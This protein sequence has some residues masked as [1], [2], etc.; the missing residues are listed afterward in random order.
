[1]VNADKSINLARVAR[2]PTPPAAGA[3]PAPAPAPAPS[4]AGPAITSPKIDVAKVVITGGDYRFT[5]RSIEPHV[6]MAI[7]E[8]TGTVAGLSSANLAKADLDLKAVVNGAGPV[9]ITGKVD[10]LGTKPSFDLK[11]DFKSPKRN[12]SDS[13]AR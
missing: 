10:P 9:A 8:F 1:V 7:A 6:S 13:V 5:D 3:T 12:L 2:I 4:P 11:F